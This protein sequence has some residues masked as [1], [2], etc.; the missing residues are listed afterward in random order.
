MK[1]YRDG[2]KITLTNTKNHKAAWSGIRTGDYGVSFSI[3]DSGEELVNHL[4]YHRLV[5]ETMAGRDVL[6]ELGF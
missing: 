5:G 4:V 3:V 1:M 2:N 6:K